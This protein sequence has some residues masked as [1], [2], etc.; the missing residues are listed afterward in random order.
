ME[1][2]AGCGLWTRGVLGVVPDPGGPCPDFPAQCYGQHEGPKGYSLLCLQAT[3]PTHVLVSSP[4]VT[5]PRTPVWPG[6]RWEFATHWLS[7]EVP[8]A[9]F[10]TA[11]VGSSAHA[12]LA[13]VTLDCAGHF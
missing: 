3:Q 5:K 6:W 13:S 10:P 11:A 2:R 7:I 4:W 1:R 8:S 12:S 9:P